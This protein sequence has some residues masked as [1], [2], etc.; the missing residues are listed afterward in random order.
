MDALPAVSALPQGRLLKTG[1][2]C[3]GLLVQGMRLEG[4]E[5]PAAQDRTDN[6]LGPAEGGDELIACLYRTHTVQAEAML[7]G[8]LESAQEI[9]PVSEKP[10]GGSQS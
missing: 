4:L 3:F 7:N 6:V 1:G 10:A 9:E 2:Q 8:I 5:F